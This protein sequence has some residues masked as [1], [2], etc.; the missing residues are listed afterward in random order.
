MRPAYWVI[1]LHLGLEG[2]LQPRELWFVDILMYNVSIT[3]VCAAH[4]LASNV[5]PVPGAPYNNT[6][7]RNTHAHIHIHNLMPFDNY[8]NMLKVETFETSSIEVIGVLK[9]QDPTGICTQDLLIA[10]Q[11]LLPLS[12]WISGGRGVQ[13]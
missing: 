7:A 6:P 11:T 9:I 5:F 13:D 2:C 10:S 8:T 1:V 4:A 3:L 12:Y